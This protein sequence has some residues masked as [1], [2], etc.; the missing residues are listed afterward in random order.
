MFH[1]LLVQFNIAINHFITCSFVSIK[2]K[3]AFIYFNAL[4]LTVSTCPCCITYIYF[5][6]VETKI[7]FSNKGTWYTLYFVHACNMQNMQRL[8]IYFFALVVKQISLW[9]FL[10]HFHIT[11]NKLRIKGKYYKRK[12]DTSNHPLFFQLSTFGQRFICS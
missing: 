10:V 5:I 4:L 3:F 8:H 2:W 12:R 6:I 11:I 1:H 7:L 9:H